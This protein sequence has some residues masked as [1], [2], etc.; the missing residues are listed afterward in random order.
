MTLRWWARISSLPRR[1]VRRLSTHY[2][3][4]AEHRH[5]WIAFEG[6]S[7]LEVYSHPA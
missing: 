3:R 2:L 5:R 6:V 7:G 4:K 1:L